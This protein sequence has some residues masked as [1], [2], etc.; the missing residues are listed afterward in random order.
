MKKKSKTILLAS[1]IM[2][3][4]ITGSIC[5]GGLPLN[6]GNFL[7]YTQV[8]YKLRFL[9]EGMRNFQPWVLYNQAPK[10]VAIDRFKEKQ[11]NTAT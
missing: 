8:G 2:S 4:L 9:R 6:G 1:I 10:T 5:Y 3:V 11:W 7:F